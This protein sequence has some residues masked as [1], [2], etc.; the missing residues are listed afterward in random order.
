VRLSEESELADKDLLGESTLA[1]LG[2]VKPELA[3]EVIEEGE[4][5]NKAK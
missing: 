4:D 1:K 5:E 2:G 3:D